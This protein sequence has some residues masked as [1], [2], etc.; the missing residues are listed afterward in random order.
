MKNNEEWIES[1]KKNI[2]LGSERINNKEYQALIKI[3]LKSYINS[4]CGSTSD[5]LHTDY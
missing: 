1:N 3:N 4:K 5:E 2:P